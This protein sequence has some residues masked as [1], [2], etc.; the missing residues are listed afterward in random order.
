[1][2]ARLAVLLAATWLAAGCGSSALTDVTGNW[3]ATDTSTQGG[4]TVTYTFA[5]QEGATNGFTIPVTFSSLS[6]TTANNCF[7]N[8]ATITGTITPGFP[9]TLAVDIYSLPNN[10]GNHA[11]LNLTLTA[12]NTSAAGTYVLAGGFGGCV[13]DLGNVT[14]TR[15]S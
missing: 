12:D 4:P 8:T 13:N 2:T 14:F 1:M 10:G 6:V 5:M 9:R 15:T 3:S 11:A 7:D